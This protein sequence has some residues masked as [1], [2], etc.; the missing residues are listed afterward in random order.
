MPALEYD[1][2]ANWHASMR[3][4]ERLI[5]CLYELRTFLIEHNVQGWANR[6]DAAIE[7]L[8]TDEGAFREIMTSFCGSGNHSI[9]KLC[10][11]ESNGHRIPEGVENAN[12]RLALL[13][14]AVLDLDAAE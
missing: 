11:S 14:R 4:H 6:T 13:V 8:T 10:I 5:F 9:S 1:R 7:L 12:K 3:N 2:A